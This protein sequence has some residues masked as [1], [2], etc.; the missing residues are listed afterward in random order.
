MSLNW[1]FGSSVLVRIQS[2]WCFMLFRWRYCYIVLL[3]HD[4]GLLWRHESVLLLLLDLVATTVCY[5]T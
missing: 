3:S 2:Q 5:K 1:V 4:A